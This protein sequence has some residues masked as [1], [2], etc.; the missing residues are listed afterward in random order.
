MGNDS[1]SKLKTKTRQNV[2][3]RQTNFVTMK[4]VDRVREEVVS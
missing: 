3:G 4:S 2:H 1:V